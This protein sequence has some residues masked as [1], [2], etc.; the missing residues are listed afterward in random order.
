MAYANILV[1]ELSPASGDQSISRETVFSFRLAP[2]GSSTTID[3]STLTIEVKVLTGSGTF[4]YNLT[5]SS[6]EVTTTVKGNSYAVEIDVDPDGAINFESKDSVMLKINV[7]DETSPTPLH[8]RQFVA[9]YQVVNMLQID[10]LNSI[11]SPFT[12]VPINYEQARISLDG[13]EASFTW[14]NWMSTYDPVVYKNDILIGSGYTPNYTDGKLSFSP[15]LSSGYNKTD[16]FDTALYEPID[17][18]NCDYR[19]SVFT[20][21][22]L[23]SYM[24]AGVANFNASFPISS[25]TVNTQNQAV[26]GAALFGGAYYLYNAVVAG[27]INQQWRVQWGEEE[28]QE[29][30]NIAKTMKEN[31]KS[32][33][34]QIIEAKKHTLA[35]GIQGIVVPEYTLP[36]GRSRFF[37][38]LFGMG[39]AF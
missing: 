27:F 36:G 33:F 32:V 12:E 29:A 3:I 4:T 28:W 7:D 22:Q 20:I 11:T 38:Y 8:M 21:Q 5:S 31:T 23:I 25:Y 2:A 14:K 15:V 18:V 34:D 6:D 1:K 35:K 37:S 19:Y 9:S 16:V 26:Q 10:A 39:G 17:R 30:L 13:S 24:R